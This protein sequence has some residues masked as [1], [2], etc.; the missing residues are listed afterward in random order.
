MD[1]IIVSQVAQLA[2]GQTLLNFILWPTFVR[3]QKNDLEM[4]QTTVRLVR[5]A[6]LGPCF[7]S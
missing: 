7:V 5:I 2:A 3:C 4:K 6:I 1:D